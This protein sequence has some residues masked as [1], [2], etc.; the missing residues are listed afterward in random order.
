MRRL[1]IYVDEDTDELLT[2]EARRS[3][4]SKAALI[5]DAVR[6]TYGVGERAPASADPIDAWIGSLDAEPG[7][8]DAVV[9]D[10]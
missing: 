8:I 10:G 4:R 2:R 7:D 9:Y 3:R 6:D 1:Q 5:R